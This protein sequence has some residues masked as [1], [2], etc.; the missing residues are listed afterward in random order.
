M[1]KKLTQENFK[2]KQLAE[3]KGELYTYY[4][5]KEERK[6]VVVRIYSSQFAVDYY[7]GI[8]LEDSEFGNYE[9]DAWPAALEVA[10]VFFSKYEFTG[11]EKED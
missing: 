8:N 1:I 3:Q 6:S 4:E 7:E 10:N 2:E 11:N 5:Y 9:G